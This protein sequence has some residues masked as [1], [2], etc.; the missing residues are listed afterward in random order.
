MSSEAALWGTFRH[1]MA[2]F[3]LWD[4]IENGIS[5]GMPDVNGIVF[6][7]PR[8]DVWIEL[9]QLHGWPKRANTIV[10]IPHYTDEQRRW[11]ATRGAAGSRVYMLVGIAPR[12]WY[13]YTWRDAVEIV[14]R[15][16]CST[17]MERSAGIC[18]GK[19]SPEMVLKVIE[20][21]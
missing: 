21:T 15:A 18:R 5:R 4:R 10:R 6:G 8:G 19:F 1:A 9:K 11:I 16:P 7:D 12:E 3:G 13:M 20:N 17:H 14:G 2:P